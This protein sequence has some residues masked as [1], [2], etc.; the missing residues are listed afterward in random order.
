LHGASRSITLPLPQV[1]TIGA[2]RI[3]V[4]MTVVVGML[5][6][7]STPA[8]S[9][10]GVLEQTHPARLDSRLAQVLEAFERGGGAEAAAQASESGIELHGDRV[11]VIV[12]TAPGTGDH[13]PA[14]ARRLGAT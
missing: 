6:F 4:L 14:A 12:E 3:C 2:V 10:A 1:P 9:Q 11:R 8:G 5:I 7:A 13:G